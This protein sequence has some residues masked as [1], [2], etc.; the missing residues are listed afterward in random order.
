MKIFSALTIALLIIFQTVGL[1]ATGTFSASGEYL[2]S[3]YDTPEIAEEIALDFAKQNAAEQAGI[4]LENYSR[5]MDSEVEEDEVKTVASSK[6]EVLTKNITR[7][8]QSNGRILLRAD[9]KA[10]VD[11]SELYN[12]LAQ[13]REQRQMAIQQ[14]KELQAMN[15]K[16]KQD[17]ADFQAKLAAIKDDVKDEDLLVEQERINREFLSKQKLEEFAVELKAYI[18]DAGI[19]LNNIQVLLADLNRIGATIDEAIKFD[20]KNFGVYFFRAGVLNTDN[21]AKKIFDYNKAIILN[22][23]QANLY[24]SRGNNY[25]N[26]KDYPAALKDYTRAIELDPKDTWALKQRADLY[27]K[28]LNEPVRAVEDYSRIIKL[29]PEDGFAYMGRGDAYASLKNYSQAVKDYTT[30]TT[31]APKFIFADHRPMAYCSRADIFVEQKKFDQAVA[32]YDKAI[33]LTKEVAKKSESWSKTFLE[34]TIALYEIKKQDALKEKN[35]AVMG[36]TAQTTQAKDIEKKFG[37][38]NSDDKNS[39]MKRANA[40]RD[41]QIYDRAIKDYSQVIKLVPKDFWAYYYRGDCYEKSNDFA[42]ALED[43]NQIIKIAPEKGICYRRRGLYYKNREDYPNALKDYTKAIEVEPDYA[44][45]YDSRGKIYIKLGDYYKAFADYDKAIEVS[46]SLR[47]KKGYLENKLIALLARA[48]MYKKQGDNDKA[49]ADYE[50]GIKLT[51]AERM[52]SIYWNPNRLKEFQGKY[53]ALKKENLPDDLETFIQSGKHNFKKGY[54]PNALRDLNRAL[55]INPNS[56]EAY[57]WRGVVYRYMR[58]FQEAFSDWEQAIKIN[59]RCEEAYFRRGLAYSDVNNHEL[60]I[61]DYNKVLE[62]N[63]NNK[64]AYANR[65]T[66]YEALGEY[67]KALADY[68]R[69]LEMEPNDRTLISMRQKLL[70]KMSN[71]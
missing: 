67:K 27:C 25:E 68:N 59:P 22:P 17:I 26:L 56:A 20:P 41:A 13:E 52:D 35:S 69:A 7:Q 16:I 63:P 18:S 37:K 34:Q 33:I 36:A 50:E 4:Y 65:A 71:D 51:S 46:T 48:E 21:R 29:E 6:V 66:N 47:D 30:A 42:R 11:T 38:I 14:Y 45:Y 10:T 8:P 55:Q 32:D 43:F 19:D 9:I 28:K 57:V 53:L 5:S 15:E 40:Y 1:A 58:K 39:L 61:S 70:E 31:I 64:Q 23:N 49:L 60:A 62:I 3:D 44:D 24:T 2:M 12:F 54:Y